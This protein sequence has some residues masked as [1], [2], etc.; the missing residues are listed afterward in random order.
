MKIK[1]FS[2]MKNRKIFR[3]LLEVLMNF[4]KKFTEPETTKFPNFSKTC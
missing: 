4:L 3:T 1:D 2:I